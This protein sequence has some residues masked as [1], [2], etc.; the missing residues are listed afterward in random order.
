MY[1]L[2]T[3]AIIIIA[4]TSIAGLF[5]AGFGTVR[6]LGQDAEHG[7]ITRRALDC[8]APTAIDACFQTESIDSLAGSPGDFGAVGA[9]DR[10]RGM[11]TSYAHCSAG[12]YYDVAGYPR[13]REEAQASL[14]EC[15]DYMAEN[16]RHAVI[17]AADLLDD[18]GDIR[19]S[20]IPGF[21]PCIY[22]GSEHGRAKCN[23][24][25]HLG[26]ILHASQD[27]Y[28]HSNW[29][30]S[31]DPARPVGPENPPGLGNEGPAAWL[32]LRLD[33]PTFPQG[34]ISGC[35]DNESFLGEERGCVYAE[36]GSHR[37]RHL[38]VN[39][40]TG[41]IDP[42]IGVGT[43]SRGAI[44]DNFERAVTAAIADSADK[45]A[46][47]REMLEVSYGATRADRMICAITHDDPVDDCA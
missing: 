6:S 10:G 21:I 44:S 36:D 9:P 11:L 27:F 26:R 42:E 35:F 29:V 3:G 18:D 28:S 41:V 2:K 19:S 1:N 16:L 22:A 17:D 34:L 15:R 47:F 45:W 43:T 38:D 40:D 13:T 23:V 33:N 25:A 39:K 8:A 20:Q 7:R 24:L 12:D 37:V 5:L 30:D 46:T 14:T 32:N 4:I 31:P